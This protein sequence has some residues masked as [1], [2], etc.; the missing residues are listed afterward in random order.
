VTEKI[1]AMFVFMVGA[2]LNAFVFGNV[3]VLM[4]R[5]DETSRRY[6]EKI[7]GIRQMLKFYQVNKTD[8]DLAH[9]VEENF[10]FF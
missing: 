6:Q 1:Y 5:F 10:S 3:A 7:Q 2:L 8:K 9:M 4:Q